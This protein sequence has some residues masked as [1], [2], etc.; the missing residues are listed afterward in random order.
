MM[1]PSCPTGSLL[2]PSV[3]YRLSRLPTI[4]GVKTQSLDACYVAGLASRE[5]QIPGA[6]YATQSAILIS[7]SGWSCRC[8]GV[9]LAFY[10]S[11]V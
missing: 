11:P 10:C 9:T 2:T 5:Q 6:R 3:A 7:V 8:K 4:E 1:E